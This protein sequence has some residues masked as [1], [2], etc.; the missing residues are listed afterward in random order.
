MTPAKLVQSLPDTIRVGPFDMRIVLVPVDQATSESRWG[1]FHSIPQVIE[2]MT[3]Y[4]TL[5]KAAD[6]LV[7]EINHAIF[8]AYGIDEKDEEERTVATFA[9][10]WVQVYRDN[11]W[12][13]DWLKRALK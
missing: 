2:L 3:T 11:P 7:H 12:L 6:T 5:F 13:L 8:W 9:T 10:G 1:A 4:P